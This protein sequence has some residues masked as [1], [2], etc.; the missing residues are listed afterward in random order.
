MWATGQKTMCEAKTIWD[1]GPPEGAR[2]QLQ[3]KRIETVC[4]KVTRC[5]RWEEEAEE[6][7]RGDRTRTLEAAKEGRKGPSRS[8]KAFTL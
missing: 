8:R 6:A 2:M 7:K 1:T 3:A 5:M 4:D